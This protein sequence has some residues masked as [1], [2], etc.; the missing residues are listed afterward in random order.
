MNILTVEQISKSYGEKVLFQDASFGMEEHDK[1]GVIGVNGTG[2]ST[3]LRIV[4]GLEAPD[5]GRIAVNNDVRISCLP[6]NPDFDPETTVLRQVFQGGD[7]MLQ[8][9]SAYIEAVERLELNP[10][11]ERLQAE[12]TRL[13]Q[14][15]DQLQA[16]SLESEAKSVLSKLGITDFGA[17]VGEL[18]G[19]QR[20]RIALASA[21]IVPSE[22][23][24]LDE[25]TNHIDNDSVAWL[26]SY[27]Q[28]RRGALLLITHDR[29]FL[30]R[31]CNVM[32][33]LDHGRLFRYEANYSRFLELKSEREEREASAEQKRQN[34]LRTELAWIRR[35]AKARTTKQKAR[36]ER[37]EKLQQEKT[38]YKSDQLDI[39]VASTRLGR[40]I[41]EISELSKS[42]GERLLIRELTY[43]A[44]PGDRVGIVGPNGSGKS[45]L[46]NMIAG[47]IEPDQG[48]V[49][50][51]QTVK[52][53]FF[54]QEHQEMDDKQRVIEYVKEEAEVVSTADGSRIT[55][56]Q[57]LERFLFSPTMQWTPIAKLSGG[58]KRRLYLLRV[59]MGAPNV[60]LLDEP[61]NDLDIQTLTVLEAYLDEFPGA[62][63]VVSHDRY[64]L[65]RTVDKIM[66]FEGEGV[67]ALHVG[68]YS[69]YADRVQQF[70]KSADAGTNSDG[71]KGKAAAAWASGDSGGG[72][73]GSSGGQK[74]QSRAERVKFSY[75]EQR[76]YE[77]IDG[78][79][80]AAEQ[81]LADIA[82]AMEQAVS[83]ASRLQELMKEQQEA[84]AELERLMDR[85]TYLNELAEKIEQQRS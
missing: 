17:K 73:A 70:A 33:E 63:F 3:F 39:S 28:R 29:Y 32:L 81:R 80:E 65:D 48:Y 77:A 46:L 9:V 78:L 72:A 71:V 57:M 8:T 49:E 15:M 26:E 53:G 23:L 34:L 47:R 16:W 82:S 24:I 31:V 74:D 75:N 64:F 13:S 66:A 6:Q 25:P 58:E 51:G 20:K 40:K 27:L 76:E 67:V 45:T 22:L 30:D 14:E 12:V 52:L 42:A 2:K 4:A 41:V 85:W 54:T 10:A 5:S 38:E 79:V 59:L 50:L 19:G 83:D 69:D 37:F 43:T 68:D 56:A 11:D 62:V 36:I 21:L 18:S 1:I 35:G 61:T 84:E 60:L 44:V 55:A 7:P